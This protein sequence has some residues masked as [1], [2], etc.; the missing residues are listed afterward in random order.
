MYLGELKLWNFRK[1]GS[2]LEEFDLSK[3]NLTINFHKGVNLLIGENDSGKS[4]IIDA[5][6]LVLKTHSF[7][8]NRISEDDFYNAYKRLRIELTFKD[9]TDEEAKHFA[10]WLGWDDSKNPY[11][12]IFLDVKR[13]DER[14]LP[15]EIRAGIDDIGSSLSAE[16]RE[17]LKVTYLK[18]LRDAE[19]ELIPK[20]NSRLSQIFMGYRLFKDG[21]EHKLVG[22]VKRTNE[23]IKNYFKENIKPDIDSFLEAFLDKESEF[24]ISEPSLKKILESLHLKIYGEKNLGLGS[25]NILFISSELLHLKNEDEGLKLALIE[26]IEAHLHPQVQLR[27][28]ENLQEKDDIQLIITTH[29]PNIGSKIKLENLFICHNGDV[30]PMGKG[31]TKLD[32]SDYKFLERFLD[33]TKANMFFA[34]G[35]ILVEGWAEELILPALAKKIGISLTQKGISIVNVGSTAFLRYCKI[36]Q[37]EDDK[38]MFIP[39]AVITDLDIKPDEYKKIDSRK[40]IKTEEDFNIDNEISKKKEKLEGQSVRVFIS[41]HWTLEYCLM[42]DSKLRVLLID[43][44]KFVFDEENR[45]ERALQNLE[46]EI[47][48]ILTK[49]SDTK[50]A[51][52]LYHR[53]FLERKISKAS[54]AQYF[55]ELLENDNSIGKDNLENI[56]SIQYLIEAIKYAAESE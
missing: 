35:V 22:E 32:E 55:A 15:Y 7:E 6:K 53:M 52:Y 40:E 33:V 21:D 23:E 5:I 48:D 10:E 27:I 8:W 24:E 13:N 18:P 49:T 56:E 20:K 41:P 45:G 39:V 50:I 1:F 30:F 16:A 38:N 44:I 34:K 36:F 14:I 42:L 54:V 28:I 37:R 11:L 43:A 12:K 47:K 31:N 51:T 25:H 2:E 29:S 26:E 46:K 17:Y 19:S 4:A 3:P 9:F